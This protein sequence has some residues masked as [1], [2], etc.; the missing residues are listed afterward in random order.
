MR[1]PMQ[2]THLLQRKSTTESVVAS[3]LEKALHDRIYPRFEVIARLD[4][5]RLKKQ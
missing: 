3:N 2:D 5:L 1:V 4:S